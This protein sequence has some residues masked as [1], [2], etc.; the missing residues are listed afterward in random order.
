[1]HNARKHKPLQ[2]ETS[3]AR[4]NDIRKQRTY[5][6]HISKIVLKSTLWSP[7]VS[8]IAQPSMVTM[9]N[10]A[11]HRMKISCSVQWLERSNARLGNNVWMPRAQ[12]RHMLVLKRRRLEHGRNF[13]DFSTLLHLKHL[14][15]S[16]KTSP[17]L[18]PRIEVRDPVPLNCSLMHRAEIPLSSWMARGLHQTFSTA[19]IKSQKARRRTRLL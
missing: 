11:N 10:H 18:Q 6:E 1:M 13:D 7:R 9:R 14:S 3:I 5:A 12:K 8:K 4:S 19:P 16:H 2:K 15:I 17:E